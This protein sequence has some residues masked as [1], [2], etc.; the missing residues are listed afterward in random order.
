MKFNV[1]HAVASFVAAAIVFEAQA[2]WMTQ[3]IP[4]VAGWNAVHLK[5][6]P[7]DA[8]CAAVFSDEAITQVSWWNRDRL[9]DGTGSSIT[10]FCNW[11][12][13][14][15]EPNTFGRVIGDHTYLVYSTAARPYFQV[16]GTPALPRGTIY[17]G[18]RNL[19]GVNVPN[20]ASDPPLLNDYFKDSKALWSETPWMRVTA[21]NE[22][23]RVGSRTQL[24][25]ASEAFWFIT[26]G[27]G[28][29]T[30]TGPFN[31]SLDKSRPTLSWSDNTD[32]RSITIRNTTTDGRVLRIG[33]IS[34]LPPP[35]GHGRCVG[36][37]GLLLESIDWS[38]GYAKRVYSPLS[39]PLVTN[40]A[41]GATFEF[42]V[43]P[44]LSAMPNTAAGDYM[45]ILEISDKGSVI[46]GETHTDGTCLYRVGVSAAGTL[47]A[48]EQSAAAGLWVGAVVLGEVNRAKMLSSD[49]AVSG[50]WDSTLMLD[51]PHPFTFRLL[52][53]V[54]DEGNAKILKQVFTAKPSAGSDATHLLTDR[55]TAIAYRERYSNATIHR[56]ASAN[57]PFME[58]L[59]LSGG[60][61]MTPDAEL[62]ATFTQAYDDKTNPFVH[63][64][65]PQHDNIAF[66][67]MR[68]SKMGSGDEGRGEY[69]SWGVTRTV[70]LKFLAEDPSNAAGQDWN[71][72]VTGGEY[73]ETVNGL[74]GQGKPIVTKGI[75][76]LS[77]V[78]DVPALTT[79]T[80]P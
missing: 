68:P 8:D 56:T 41:A 17:L 57:F 72:T 33:R 74:T 48:N 66:N 38:E 52:M 5:V 75:F 24:S 32:A 9:D 44:N 62:T 73:T 20:I 11:Y 18:E 70:T 63:S 69:E 47:A 28:I 3:D 23:L 4:L 12:R 51:A 53:H 6:H 37:V 19:V 40:I 7:A 30:F 35:T 43:K 78:N 54:D 14:S 65:H 58:P 60:A 15:A 50:Q 77:K 76:R 61:F 13:S 16:V 80:I 34:S 2:Q 46:D 39:F 42:R 21:E 25:N 59:A 10:D 22:A 67:N 26:A 45:S 36:D 55:S 79:E 1:V 64:F 29:S 71:R 31:V 27:S 49:D